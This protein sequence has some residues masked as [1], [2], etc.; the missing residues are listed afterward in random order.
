MNNHIQSILSALSKNKVKFVVCGGVALVL[1]GIERLTMDID[2]AVPMDADNLQTLITTLKNIGMTPRAPIPAESLLDPDKRKI[3]AEEKDALV[4]TFIDI[5]NPYKQV[6]IFIGSDDL[7]SNLIK[8]A[9]AV[10]IQ[11]A[12]IDIISIANLIKMKEEMNSPREKDILDIHEL[13]KLLK[14]KNG[15]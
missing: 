4:F 2:I 1:H 7:Y 13:Q 14:A 8:D 15:E 5:Q 12:M 3:M 6:D 11:D 9:A 10:K